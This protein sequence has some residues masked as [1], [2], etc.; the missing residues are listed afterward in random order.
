[1]KNT[2]YFLSPQ[3]P[4]IVS[5]LFPLLLLLCIVYHSVLC[6]VILWKEKLHSLQLSDITILLMGVDHS[7]PDKINKALCMEM[8]GDDFSE[9]GE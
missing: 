8:A 7:L 5:F 4:G 3:I 9:D 2:S 6:L 1:M